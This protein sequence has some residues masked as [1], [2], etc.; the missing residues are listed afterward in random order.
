MKSLILLLMLTGTASSF[1]CDEISGVYKS[2]SESH[3]N[4]VISIS[5]EDLNVN[6]SNYW[7]GGEG[8]NYGEERYEVNSDFTGYCQKQGEDYI[9]KFDGK[10]ILFSFDKNLS[11][12]ELGEDRSLPGI[13]GVLF[14]EYETNLW[15]FN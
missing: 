4:Y 5:G 14:G 15:K 1:S 3:W 7:Y 8:K 13:S 10:K 11:L 6:Y 9:L 2:V 12:D